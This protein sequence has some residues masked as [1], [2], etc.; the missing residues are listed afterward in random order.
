MRWQ[1][2][3]RSS[4]LDDRRGMPVGLIG[5]GGGMIAVGLIVA[6]L[7]GD[8]TPFLQEGFSRAIQTQQ[9]QSSNIPKEE[10]DKL[11][12]FVSVVLAGTEDTWHTQFNAMGMRYTEP[13]LVLFGGAVQS[14]CGN[15][16]RAMGP[17]YCPLDQKVYL[18]LDFFHELDKRFGAPGDFAQAYVVA[19]EVGHHVQNLLG[20][21]DETREAQQRLPRAQANT[22]SVKTELMADC[23]AGI[24]AHQTQQAGLLDNGDVEEALN[25]ASKIGDDT[26]QQRTRGQVVP[27][28]FTHGSSAQ[29]Y[30]WF[31]TGFDTGQI[32]ACN[33]FR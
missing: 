33:T 27:D 24:W 8:P 17:F 18:D 3:R 6:L 2:G 16:V 25:A 12:D 26:L 4:N 22:V 5:G 1:M 15:A 28:S 19:H 7:G 23:L 21:L 30:Q 10:Q 20:V 11:A 13:Q 31:K 29:R 14:A 32:D 9:L